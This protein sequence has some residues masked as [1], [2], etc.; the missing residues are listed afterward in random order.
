MPSGRGYVIVSRRAYASVMLTDLVIWNLRS[1]SPE[2]QHGT[3]KI[4]G[5]WFGSMFLLF[6][7][8][9]L[10]ETN[11]APGN[12]WLEDEIPFGMA[13]FQG[14]LL[15][16]SGRVFSGSGRLFCC[17]WMASTKEWCLV[18]GGISSWRGTGKLLG[19]D[20][21]RWLGW[22]ASVYTPEI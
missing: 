13:H 16:V 10:P 3:Q 9:T 12:Q 22:V 2:N 8:A 6:P 1:Y 18:H 14:L 7:K 21:E 4:G 19:S 20:H 5:L 15:F 17:R 11:I